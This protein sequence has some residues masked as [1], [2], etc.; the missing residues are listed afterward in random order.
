MLERIV[1]VRGRG[2]AGIERIDPGLRILVAVHLRPAILGGAQGF[3]SILLDLAQRLLGGRE[4]AGRGLDHGRGRSPAAGA[5]D[6][7]PEGG[8]LVAGRDMLGDGGADEVAVFQED[9]FG[10][11]IIA[12]GLAEEG[13]LDRLVCGI[14]REAAGGGEIGMLLFPL[15]DG[16]QGHAECSGEILVEG[17]ALGERA[18]DGDQ[19]KAVA[20]RVGHG[21]DAD[22]VDGIAASDQ[23]LSVI[24][25]DLSA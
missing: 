13:A 5:P 8:G 10:L 18:G 23:E 12:G 7:Q 17:A 15:A 1:V 9:A 16:L 25:P 19:G 3:V 4:G 11:A 14:G 21:R 6:A 22:T 20:T 24:S 2:S